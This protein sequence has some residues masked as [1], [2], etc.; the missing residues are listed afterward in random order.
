MT[1]AIERV[2]VGP[3][4]TL[5]VYLGVSRPDNW[6]D[7]HQTALTPALV[8]SIITGALSEGWDPDGR[9][10]AFE[11]EYALVKDKP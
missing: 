4:R 7:P 11:Y 9:G 5:L 8:R 6:I 2:G 1:V 10:H 3:S